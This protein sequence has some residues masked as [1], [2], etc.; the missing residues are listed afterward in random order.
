MEDD[1]DNEVMSTTPAAASDV[2]EVRV[3][4]GR[5]GR[6][7]R[8]AER[9]EEYLQDSL[10]K[11]DPLQA[12]LGASVADLMHIRSKLAESIR[13]ELGTGPVTLEEYRT[14][15][16]PAVSS[17]LLLDR[18]IVSYARLGHDLK[19]AESSEGTDPRRRGSQGDHGKRS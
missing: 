16:A 17:L 14:D 19:R 2:R 15:F 3:S 4:G 13:A 10:D 5:V 8:R 1:H 12:G 11:E 9:I 7:A 18:Y 6:A